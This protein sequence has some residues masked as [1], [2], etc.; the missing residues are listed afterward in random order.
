M[1]VFI[2]RVMPDFA[3]EKQ[4]EGHK[5]KSSITLKKRR[6]QCFFVFIKPSKSFRCYKLCEK[7]GK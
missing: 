1:T 6:E 4:R 7:I 2:Q 5:K 3:P